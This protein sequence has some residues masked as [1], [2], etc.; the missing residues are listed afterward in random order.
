MN[1]E[2]KV[3]NLLLY[4]IYRDFNDNYCNNKDIFCFNNKKIIAID[5]IEYD[6]DKRYTLQKIMTIKPYYVSQIIF[7]KII[8]EICNKQVDFI[9]RDII[10]DDNYV[11]ETEEFYSLE[12]YIGHRQLINIYKMVFN[13]LEEYNTS[14]KLIKL[15]YQGYDFELTKQGVLSACAPIGTIRDLT[16]NDKFNKLILGV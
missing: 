2:V 7:H 5:E 13:L 9:I 12:E 15:N 3:V 8:R 14:I 11:T 16:T 4:R 1:C 10:F 6:R